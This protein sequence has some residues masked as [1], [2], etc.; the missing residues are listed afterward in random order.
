VSTYD[1]ALQHLR[2]FATAYPEHNEFVVVLTQDV[3]ALERE[4]R[5]AVNE[6]N[7]LAVV[8]SSQ[9]D[10]IQALRLRVAELE[11]LLG[12]ATAPEDPNQGAEQIQHHPTGTT[13]SDTLALMAQGT[14]TPGGM[15]VLHLGA[16]VHGALE[17]DAR[18]VPLL[19]GRT[20]RLAGAPLAAITGVRLFEAGAASS[21]LELWGVA[22]RGVVH[23]I[24]PG[25]TLRTLHGGKLAAAK[26]AGPGVPL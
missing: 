7:A 11:A 4:R 15:S 1:T 2:R 9:R 10:E 3:N 26:D 6:R 21:S 19:R 24:A 23:V 14:I 18:H 25:F 8:V 20:L 12:A 17:L 16:G 13:L 22:T 5:A